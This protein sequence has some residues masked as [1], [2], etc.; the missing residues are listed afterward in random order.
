MSKLSTVAE[1]FG[2]TEEEICIRTNCCRRDMQRIL[3]PDTVMYPGEIRDLVFKLSVL[4]MKVKD[5]D[6]QIALQR[7]AERQEY[8]D[9]LG[10]EHGIDL[11]PFE[12][13]F[14]F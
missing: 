2:M 5:R 3:E 4:S 12:D 14:I 9:N 7:N 8:L 1:K 6:I 11:D 10:L 13:P